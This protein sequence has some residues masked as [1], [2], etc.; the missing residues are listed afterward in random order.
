MKDSGTV[1]AGIIAA[2]TAGEEQWRPLQILVVVL[3]FVLN[4]LDGADLL[5]MSFV[6]PVLSSEWSIG[7]ERLGI[8]FSASLAGMAVGCLFVAPSSDVFGRRKLMLAALTVVSLTMIASGYAANVTQLMAARFL[9]GIGV[10]TIGVTMTAMA[11]EYA[12]ARHSSFAAGLVQAGWPF[13]SIITAF[14]AAALIETAGWRPLFIGIGATSLALLVLIFF[15]LPESLSFLV[16]RKPDSPE[17]C[18]ISKRL[19]VTVDRGAAVDSTPR[20]SVAALFGDGRARSSV[21]LWTAVAFGYFVL[22]FVISWIPKLTAD[23]GLPVD[24]AI[25]AGATYNFGAFLGTMLMGYLAIRFRVKRVISILFLLAAIVLVFFGGVRLPVAP[26]LATAFLIGVTVQGGFNGF[27][28][29]AAKLYPPEMRGTGIGWALGVGRIGAVMGPIF[30]GVLL[31]AG[32]SFAMI[33]GIYA[34]VVLIAA[35]LCSFVKEPAL[36]EK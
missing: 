15:L 30:G 34:V 36:Q 14:A 19:G 24:K 2:Q 10:G 7:P 20:I 6:A 25:Y 33:F 32:A 18:R 3:C 1:G 5:I 31:G 35:V 29:L 16:R 11:T 22:Y 9:V 4:M 23:A 28:A 8:L 26:T 21:F 13:G 17:I 27:W 12:P